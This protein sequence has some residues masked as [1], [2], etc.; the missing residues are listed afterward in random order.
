MC[1][2]GAG[3]TAQRDSSKRNELIKE[4]TLTWPWTLMEEEEEAVENLNAFVPNPW[5]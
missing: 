4:G 2:A 1:V 3:Q 5:V